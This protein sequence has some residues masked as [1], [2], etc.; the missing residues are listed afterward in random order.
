MKFIDFFKESV[1][2][3]RL[4]AA[5]QLASVVG[6]TAPPPGSL[7]GEASTGWEQDGPSGRGEVHRA[8]VGVPQGGPGMNK[9]WMVK[10]VSRTGGASDWLFVDAGSRDEVSALIEDSETRIVEVIEDPVEM[11]ETVAW[12]FGSVALVTDL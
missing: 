3:A 8:E 12:E 6:F 5:M 10:A 2:G 4:N 7:A 11:A 1:F 9:L